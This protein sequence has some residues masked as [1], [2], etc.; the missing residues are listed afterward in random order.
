M[1]QPSFLVVGTGLLV[2]GILI[3][4][5][6]V[7]I[8]HHSTVHADSLDNATAEK[9]YRELSTE[10]SALVDGSILLSKIASVTTPSV[11]HIQSERRSAGR[12]GTEEETGSGVILTSSKSSGYFVVTNCH[13]IDRT[14]LMRSQFTCMTDVCCDPRKSGRIANRISPF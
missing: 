13:V 2:T 8:P 3:G 14:P 11:V 4:A 10:S 9:V 1:R 7:S 5:G 6:F 12:G